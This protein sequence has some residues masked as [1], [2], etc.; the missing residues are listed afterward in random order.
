[1]LSK[2]Y[3][4][5]LIAFQIEIFQADAVAQVN[6]RQLTFIGYEILKFRELADVQCLQVLAARKVQ[7]FKICQEFQSFT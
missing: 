4:C 5:Y 1:M 7:V 3:V 2:S 6:L